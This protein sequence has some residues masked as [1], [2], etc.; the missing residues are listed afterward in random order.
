MHI[1]LPGFVLQIINT[2]KKNNYEIYVVG[3]V[4]RDILTGRQTEDWDFTTNAT[5]QQMLQILPE[6]A[7]YDN[8]F[9]TVM[10]PIEKLSTPIDITTFRTEES[11][12]DSRRPDKVNWGLSLEE[13]LK[14]RDFTINAMA[15]KT[16]SSQAPAGSKKKDV[17][18]DIDL[19]DQFGGKKD[20]DKK[21]IRSVG[22]PNERFSEDALRMMRAVRIATQLG[23]RIEPKTLDAIK[24]NAGMIQKIAKERV[25]DEFFKILLSPQ[26]QK[27]ILK[28]R[29][30]GLLPEIMPELE[31]TFGVE[32]K[33]PGRH[34]IDDVG[35]HLIKSLKEC[36]SDD[37]IVRFATLIHDIGKPQTFKILESGT[38]TFYNHEVVGGRIAKQIADR[39]KLSKKQKN[40]LYKLVRYH[41]F[42]VNE[43][44]TDSAIRRFIRK[45]TPEL[46][47]D[48]LEL[49][50]ADRIGSGARETSW[51]T[52]DFKSRLQEVQ[53]QPFTV[54]DLKI[55]GNDVMRELN[56]KP[57]RE[58]GEILKKL[59]K[60]V[61]GKKVENEKGVLLERLKNVTKK[62]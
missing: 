5:P 45:V 17:L 54:H 1:N 53:K 46:V 6:E 34:H 8:A 16:D 15:L 24:A 48:M 56:I 30:S 41:Q 3:G 20:L 57:G 7:F 22:D 58:V 23:F 21:V 39:L 38:I 29:D 40:K 33:S 61:V 35:T 14:R 43:K 10:L 27:G 4:V 18:T 36:R 51:R 12:S 28:L 31:K 37:V 19:I 47:D 52:E 42:T 44:Q 59:Y 25:R 2:F 13:D 55:D 26:P 60:D 62:T 32:Q 9:G 49:R 50:R 11:Y